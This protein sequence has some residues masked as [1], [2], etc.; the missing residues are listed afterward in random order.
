MS[1]LP[2]EFT[3]IDDL[4]KWAGITNRDDSLVMGLVEFAQRYIHETF[5]DSHNWAHYAGRSDIKRE[6]AELAIRL[7]NS[8]ETRKVPSLDKTH[9]LASQIN[10]ENIPNISGKPGMP[11]PPP[12]FCTL[13]A[14]YDVSLVKGEEPMEEVQA[15]PSE[16]P[17]TH[18]VKPEMTFDMPSDLG[19][20]DSSFLTEPPSQPL[21]SQP[22]QPS[23]PEPESQFPEFGSMS[24]M[25][26]PFG[27]EFEFE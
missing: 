1:D 12:R 11:C 6:D 7:K 18:E 5:I 3:E 22:Q 17:S 25:D 14:N 4:L 8:F 23:K 2:L 26:F 24:G 20:L 15:M 9:S 27:D 10:S 21:P 19:F 16:L 13:A